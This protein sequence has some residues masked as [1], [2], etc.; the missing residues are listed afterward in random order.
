MSFKISYIKFINYFG[1]MKF[2]DVIPSTLLI[3]WS[4]EFLF[5]GRGKVIVLIVDTLFK[6][7]PLRVHTHYIFKCLYGKKYTNLNFLIL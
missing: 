7:N 1:G 5:G 2:N 4:F 6:T 3:R